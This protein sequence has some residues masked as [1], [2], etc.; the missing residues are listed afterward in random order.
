MPAKIGFRAIIRQATSSQHP[1]MKHPC[2]SLCS[3]GEN[4]WSFIGSSLKLKETVGLP[5]LG[6]LAFSQRVERVSMAC[7]LKV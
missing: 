1:R 2:K 7:V 6:A 5:E 3:L 4:I